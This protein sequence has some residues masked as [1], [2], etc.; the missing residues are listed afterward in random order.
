MIKQRDD[1][2]EEL[3]KVFD[4]YIKYYGN[5]KTA[6]TILKK[7]VADLKQDQILKELGYG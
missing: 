5:Y 7:D 1:I 6:V 2:V 3:G 4:K